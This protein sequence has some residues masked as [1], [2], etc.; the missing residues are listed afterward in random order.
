MA[1]LLERP[2]LDRGGRY[3][4][5]AQCLSVLQAITMIINGDYV[6]HK[7]LEGFYGLHEPMNHF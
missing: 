1:I 6:V 4:G 5:V 2:G 7:K 3:A